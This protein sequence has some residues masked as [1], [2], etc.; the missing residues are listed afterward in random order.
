MRK[1]FLVTLLG[2]AAAPLM[3]HGFGLK[4][5]ASH[6]PIGVMGDHMHREGEFMFSYRFMLMNMDGNL[7]GSD[8]LSKADVHADFM[9]APLE[10]SMQMHMLG[11]M[12][13][14]HDNLTLMAMLPYTFIEMDHETRT[15]VNFTTK[16]DGVGDVKLSALYRLWEVEQH[17]VHLNFGFSFPTGSINERDET[18]AGA[19]Q[20]LPYPMQI[21]SGTPSVLPGITYSG[22]YFE[23]SWGAQIKGDIKL[24]RNA[25]N[26]AVGDSATATAW[27]AYS[28]NDMFSASGRLA[29]SVVEDYDGANPDLNPAMVPTADPD[30][31]SGHR[32][33][34]LLGV[35]AFFD[36]GAPQNFRAALEFGLP[37]AQ[38]L[39]GPQLQTEWTITVGLQYAF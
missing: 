30:R 17:H 7:D 34:A 39:D 13:A 35:N 28:F 5:P 20:P 10:M 21:G 36:L 24:G 32:L 25:K 33:D 8:E 15:G 4:G 31:R 29:W 6:A 14:P 12:W 2:L 18:P 38:S 1:T 3:A 26:Y 11:F 27:Y 9:V 19:D 37:V 23:H 22:F 16:A